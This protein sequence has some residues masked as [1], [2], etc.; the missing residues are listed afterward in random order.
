V[1]VLWALWSPSDSHAGEDNPWHHTMGT[2]AAMARA[3]TY[4]DRHIGLVTSAHGVTGKLPKEATSRC[5]TPTMN[6]Y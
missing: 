6:A 2:M 4:G 3:M 1:G 5:R